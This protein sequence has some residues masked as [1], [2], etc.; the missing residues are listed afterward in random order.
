MKTEPINRSTFIKMLFCDQIFQSLE[1][2]ESLYFTAL[3]IEFHAA[4]KDEEITEQDLLRIN[5][6]HLSAMSVY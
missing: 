3:D 6:D 4:G 5:S 1:L 2:E